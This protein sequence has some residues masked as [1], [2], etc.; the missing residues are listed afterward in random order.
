LRMWSDSLASF[1]NKHRW[2]VRIARVAAASERSPGSARVSFWSASGMTDDSRRA[3]TEQEQNP[4]PSRMSQKVRDSGPSLGSPVSALSAR[5]RRC[6]S[7]RWDSD[8]R[9][10]VDHSPTGRTRL[11]AV[12]PDQLGSGEEPQ[13]AAVGRGQRTRQMRELA[14]VLSRYGPRWCAAGHVVVTE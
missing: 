10:K 14:R 1:S 5:T 8:A 4:H 12:I 3:S 9:Q 11:L 13:K 2:D 7:G 6:G